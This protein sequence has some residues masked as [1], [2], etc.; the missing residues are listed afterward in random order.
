[1]AAVLQQRTLESLHSLAD[2]R[3]LVFKALYTNAFCIRTI[4][5]MLRSIPLVADEV[6]IA[7]LYP[8]VSLFCSFLFNQ[9][10]FTYKNVCLFAFVF[11]CCFAYSLR[12]RFFMGRCN[13]T[14]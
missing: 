3:R 12:I 7:N 8:G 6:G 4:S 9:T 10:R 5:S 1:M 13:D 14:I 11:V 2:R